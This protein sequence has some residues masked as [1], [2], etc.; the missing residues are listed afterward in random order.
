LGKEIVDL[1]FCGS[2]SNIGG[3]TFD[4]VIWTW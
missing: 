3:A 1:A 2:V 4:E